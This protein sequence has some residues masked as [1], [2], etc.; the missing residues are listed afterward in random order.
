M[1]TASASG[2]ISYNFSALDVLYDGIMA[3]GVT[4][5]VELSFMPTA[6]ANCT[7]G[8]CPTGMHYRGVE[9]HPRSWPLWGDLVGAF[10]AHMVQR[11]GIEELAT[12]RFEVVSGLP[13]N[14]RREGG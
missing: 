12:W 10:T 14:I 9:A 7:P 13:C 6:I 8:R 11:H 2:E 5:I 1:A 3:A 4:P